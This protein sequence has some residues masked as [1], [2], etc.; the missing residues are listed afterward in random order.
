MPLN[1]ITLY[2]QSFGHFSAM[3]LPG[4]M[5]LCQYPCLFMYACVHNCSSE[6]FLGPCRQKFV[7]NYGVIEC[8]PLVLMG[9]DKTVSHNIALILPFWC[10]LN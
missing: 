7:K 9:L 5:R 2:S 6:S 4:L 1:L 3:Y 10:T 8:D